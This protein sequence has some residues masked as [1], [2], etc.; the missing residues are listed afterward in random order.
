MHG[1][2]ETAS[3]AFGSEIGYTNFGGEY[4]F[5]YTLAKLHTLTSSFK[6]GFAD[7][8]TP[9]SHQYSIGGQYSFFGMRENEYIGKQIFLGS[10]DYRIFLPV[11]IFFDTYFQIR[12]DIGS[13]WK[14]VDEIQLADLKH[15]LG[16]TLSFN[17]PI[18]PADFSVGRS[19]HFVRNFPAN[20]ISMGPVFFYFSIGYYY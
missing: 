5:S 10:F 18:G 11:R 15:G 8:T 17:T 13:T 6:V 9:I 14:E 3:T 16:A 12:Y 7:K 20:P 19:F 2:Y 4:Q 1:F